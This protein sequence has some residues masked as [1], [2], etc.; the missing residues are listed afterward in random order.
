MKTLLW[1]PLMSWRP[2]VFMFCSNFFSEHWSFFFTINC[3]FQ[4][5][6]HS[7]CFA[8]WSIFFNRIVK[9]IHFCLLL[10]MKI[11]I[12]KTC[13]ST[14]KVKKMFFMIYHYKIDE[15]GS[16]LSSRYCQTNWFEMEDRSFQACGE[17]SF[18]FPFQGDE[19]SWNVFLNFKN[20]VHRGNLIDIWQMSWQTHNLNYGQT[21]HT[22]ENFISRFDMDIFFN[23]WHHRGC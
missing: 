6:F 19:K 8:W 16:Y 13:S 10:A 4:N 23:L 21:I 20:H 2:L 7:L 11:I 14:V 3:F 5:A 15:N 18:Q 1:H 12:R 9:K 22:T 17:E